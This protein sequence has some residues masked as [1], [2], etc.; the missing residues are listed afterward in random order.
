MNI[1][2]VVAPVGTVAMQILPWLLVIARCRSLAVPVEHVWLVRALGR[3]IPVRV[4]IRTRRGAMVRVRS[5]HVMPSGP[6]VHIGCAMM[7]SRWTAAMEHKAT[8][9]TET[10]VLCTAAT[11][12]ITTVTTVSMAV[13]EHLAGWERQG[14]E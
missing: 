6:G 11:I 14:N 12:K 10:T 9:S 2:I 13:A 3:V 1:A 8:T 5:N 7:G 4:A